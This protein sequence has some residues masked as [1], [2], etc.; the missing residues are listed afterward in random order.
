MFAVSVLA[1]GE[2]PEKRNIN[3]SASLQMF[4]GTLYLLLIGKSEVIVA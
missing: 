2:Y 1:Q 3:V 4:E